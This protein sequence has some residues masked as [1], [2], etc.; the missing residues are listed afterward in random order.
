M[1]TG[2]ASWSRRPLDGRGAAATISLAVAVA[3]LAFAWPWLSPTTA[4]GGLERYAPERDGAS[5]LIRNYGP[6]GRM[7]S[8]ESRNLAFVPDL[9]AMNDLR[10]AQQVAIQKPYLE[11]GETGIPAQSL[12]SRMADV[13][14]AQ[15]RSRALNAGGKTE[16]ATDLLVHDPRGESL[17]GSYDAEND[18]DLIFEPHLLVLPSDLGPDREGWSS[19]GTFAGMDY[20]SRGRVIGAGPFESD[21]GSFDDCLRVELTLTISQGDERVRDTTFRDRY[22]AGVGLVESEEESGGELT[23]R[24]VVLATDRITGDAG[25]EPPTLSE[26]Q[27]SPG[28]PGGWSL[29]RLTRTLPTGYVAEST[30]SPVYVPTDPPVLLAAGRGGDLLALDPESGEVA[31][32]FHAGGTVYGQP[33]FDPRSGRIFFGATDKRL[34]A[35]DARGLFLWSFATGD[36]VAGRPL[37]AGDTV[38][39]GGEDRSVHGLDAATGERRWSYN[40][41]GPVASSAALAG[42]TAV[43]GS[44]DGAV[45]GLDPGTG[46]RRWLHAT[47]GP[48]EAAVT[49]DG[50]GGDTAYVASRDGNLYALDGATGEEAWRSNAGLALDTAPTLGEDAVF[51]VNAAGR[52]LAFDRKSGA[53]LWETDDERYAGSPALAGGS[54]IVA[55]KNGDVYR[56]GANGEREQTWESSGA[57][58]GELTAPDFQLGPAVGGG[59]VWLADSNATVSRLGPVKGGPAPLAAAWLHDF[60]ESPFDGGILAYTAADYQGRALVLDSEKDIYL[61][62]PATGE[63]ERAGSLAPEGGDLTAEPV[64]AGDTLLTATGGT[65]HA[66][67]LP[68]G[69]ELWRFEGEGTS[70]RPPAI[71]GDRVYWVS[72]GDGDPGEATGALHA[73]DLASGEEEWRTPLEGFGSAGGVIIRDGTVFTSTAAFDA[74]TGERKWKADVGGSEVGGPALD[75]ER[76]FVGLT[77]TK[78][79]R[80]SVAALDAGDGRELWRADLGGDTLDATERPWVSGDTVIISTTAGDVI[81]LD[82]ASGKERWRYEPPVPQ[83]GA[84]TVEEGR[85]WLALQDGEAFVLDAESGKAVG[86]FAELDLALDDFDFF[87]RPVVVGGEVVFPLGGHLL[88]LEEEPGGGP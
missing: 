73:L 63:G 51:V 79:E 49:S 38:I 6:E 48:V 23:Q 3:A 36:N 44:D 88:G 83:L 12:A 59:A 61:I 76:L 66:A 7:V 11:P 5:M 65:L 47:G 62:D 17:V 84:I 56:F 2:V 39:F 8:W 43:I 33:A 16:D 54:L 35:L 55:G 34:Y 10:R 75:G 31:W 24:S 77:G 60:T 20:E 50:S 87:Q 28:D 82:A 1:A 78:G 81:G 52:L 13:Q 69:E 45:Y 64:V 41:G 80:G 85:V 29:A 42:G 14:V 68:D 21:L 4:G 70:L 9:R 27:S 71:A 19:E 58:A 40:T 30:I 46:E 53:K 32:R 86:R 22:C 67:G 25:M 18:R 26:E 74:A 37:V 72:A 57:G 15:S